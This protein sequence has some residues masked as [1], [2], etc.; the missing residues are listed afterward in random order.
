MPERSERFAAGLASAIGAYTL[1]G[2]L[3]I[4]WKFID[5]VPAPEILAHR[6]VW[7]FVFLTGLLAVCRRIGPTCREMAAIAADRKRLGGVLATAVLVTLNWLVYIWAVNNNRIIET[8]LGYYIN[9]LVSV[10]LGVVILKERLTFWQTAAVGLAGV[11]VLNLAVHFGAVPWVALTLAFSFGLYGLGRKLLGIGAIT[12][13]TLETLLLSPAA[14][15]YI[16]WLH[17]HGGAFTAAQPGADALLA[18][19]GVV[20]AVPLVLFANGANHLPLTI[21]G[22]AQFL[23]PTIA[24]FVGIFLYRENFSAAHCA[25]FVCIWAA[26][27]VFSAART[28]VFGRVEAAIAKAI[29]I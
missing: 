14:L 29:K 22:F 4:Y 26:L 11:G 17:S 24:L 9:P 8:S 7:S 5:Q 27:A 15:F 20:T 6:I 25:S 16:A 23:S 12:G 18:G 21:L 3:P 2:F 1:W 28:K 13:I 19:A 10:L